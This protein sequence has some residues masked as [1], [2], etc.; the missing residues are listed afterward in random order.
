MGAIDQQISSR[1]AGVPGLEPR[2]TEPESVVLPITPY[3]NG[4]H[5]SRLAAEAAGSNLHA[6]P[7]PTKSSGGEDRHTLIRTSVSSAATSPKQAVEQIRAAHG[8]RAG[9]AHNSPRQPHSQAHQRRYPLDSPK[10]LLAPLPSGRPYA[11]P[12]T[13]PQ[14]C[15][16]WYSQDSLP[17]S[18]AVPDCRPGTERL[19]TGPQGPAHRRT[20]QRLRRS[21]QLEEP[22]RQTVSLQVPHSDTIGH[23]LCIMDDAQRDDHQ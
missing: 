20:R 2:I 11:H 23:A 3:P 22:L 15:R 1:S 4:F 17:R 13:A 7:A 6:H 5:L 9:A 12:S 14:P 18:W 21:Q 19:R 16:S 10:Y 8:A